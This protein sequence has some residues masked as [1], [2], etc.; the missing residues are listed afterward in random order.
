MILY[1][2]SQ[3][4]FSLYIRIL[5]LRLCRAVS[6]QDNWLNLTFRIRSLTFIQFVIF[7]EQTCW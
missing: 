5:H 1:A 3:L 2:L 7:M 4:T 6:I